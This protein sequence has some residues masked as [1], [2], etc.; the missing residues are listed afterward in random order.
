MN[1]ITPNAN[2][3]LEEI[4]LKSLEAIF[5]YL[6]VF[7]EKLTRK[8][9]HELTNKKINTPFKD[10]PE[11]RSWVINKYLKSIQQKKY[12]T[13]RTTVPDELV[14]LIL[15]KVYKYDVSQRANIQK[16]YI[17]QKQVEQKVV[18]DLL[19]KY[20]AKEGFKYGYYDA[21]GEILR[22]IDIIK[23]GKNGKWISFQIKN[24]DN[25]KNSTV[26]KGTET[27]IIKW[28]RRKSKTGETNWKSFPDE[29]LRIKL[30]EKGFQDF[31]WKYFGLEDADN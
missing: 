3:E 20:I 10:S 19:Q 21:S 9:N 15:E 4:E 27:E 24:S 18:G 8:K 30:S 12:S 2:I 16:S 11:M 22:T 17:D 29:E 7:P 31:I 5:D 13:K 23:K 25:T 1:E 26:S 6:K 14:S 28:E